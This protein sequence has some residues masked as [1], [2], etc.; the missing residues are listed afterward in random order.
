MAEAATGVVARENFVESLASWGTLTHCLHY[1]GSCQQGEITS[2][3][4][5]PLLENLKFECY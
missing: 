4:C 1:S 5:F 3:S 2:F